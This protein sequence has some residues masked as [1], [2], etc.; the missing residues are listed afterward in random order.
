MIPLAWVASGCAPKEESIPFDVMT[1]LGNVPAN[2]LGRVVSHEHVLVDFIGADQTNASRW[3]D[4]EVIRVVLPYLEKL[5]A[6][7]CKTFFDFTPAYLGRDVMLLQR[8][9]EESGLNIITNTGFY[10]ARNNMY[11]P[12]FVSTSSADELADMWV[13]EFVDGIEGTGIRP[14]FL[15]IGVDPE[16]LSPLHAKL[17]RAAARAHKATGLTIAVHTGAGIPALQQIDV[18]A[19]EGVHPSAWIWVHAQFESDNKKHNE[20]ARKGA[21]VGF[22]GLRPDQSDRYIALLQNMKSAGLLDHV[23]LS[24]DAGWYSAGE[25]NGGQFRGYDYLYAEFIDQL[26]AARFT[27]SEIE[28][29]VVTN[30]ARAFGIRQRLL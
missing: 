12:E 18:L 16:S 14:G 25:E 6:S 17:I 9:S 2:E 26:R 3:D 7:G 4:D 10:G 15:K 23:L 22:D 21:W 8:L 30:P 29:L 20:A 11:L 27:S 13:R 1:V 5:V 24:H 28:G 19:E